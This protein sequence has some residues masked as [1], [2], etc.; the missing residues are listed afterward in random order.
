MTKIKLPSPRNQGV[1]HLM[2]GN[3]TNA[4]AYATT[5]ESVLLMT[6]ILNAQ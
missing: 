6:I 1:Y 2:Q 3:P 5:T 4:M